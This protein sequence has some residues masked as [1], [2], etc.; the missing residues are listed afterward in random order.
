[1]TMGARLV[2]VGLAVLSGALLFVSD[3][4]L[5]AWPLQTLA[6]L[7][8]L[9]AL[10][11]LCA[12]RRAALLAGLAL[13][14][15][16]TLPLLRVLEF[17]LFMGL[18]LALYLSLLWMLIGLGIYLLRD[19]PS[20]LG[21]LAAGAVAV[22]VEWVDF[23]VVPVWG[24]AQCFARVWSAAPLVAQLVAAGGVTVLVFVLVGGQALMGRLLWGAPRERLPSA[25]A[26]AALLAL[27]GG[28]CAW[29]YT[30]PSRGE[31]T[32]AALG[33]TGAD[34]QARGLTRPAPPGSYPVAEPRALFDGLYQPL[35]LEAARRGAELI[36]S[37]EVGFFLEPGDEAELLERAARLAH[38]LR[39]A[40]VIGYFSRGS[41]TN[42][43]VLLD[44]RSGLRLEYEKTH[45]IPFVEKYQ[46]GPGAI[47][48]VIL[49]T[50]GERLRVGLMI[51][52]DDNFTD[53]ARGHGRAGTALMVVPTNDWKQVKDFHLENAIFRA[54]ENRYAVVRAASNGVS[55]II[56]PRGQVLARRDP[57]VEG[58]GLA[59][60]RVPLGGGPTLYAR[61]GGWP[62]LAS[63]ALLGGGWLWRRRRGRGPRP[64]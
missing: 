38:R 59:L 4:P 20:P 24:T 31:L 49:R 9:F 57:F 32:V 55:A 52:Q 5:H 61:L 60:A 27:A 22:L 28:W 35:V 36:A 16:E 41:K 17:P 7:P 54:V 63:L 46:P 43:A 8:F 58:P 39:R 26:L 40:L 13:G 34:L 42:R 25:I 44:G 2:F 29:S 15:A 23:T 1:M 45:L 3:Y 12:S 6:L 18:P 64:C 11:R 21:P 10:E 51:C 50:E 56:S 47:A 53:L 19:W 37:P 48:S 14:L 62:P 30:R 33:W